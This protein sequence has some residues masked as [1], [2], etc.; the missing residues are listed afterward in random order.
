M[1]IQALQE[2]LD[3]LTAQL[4][5]SEALVDGLVVP[6]DSDMAHGLTQ[7]LNTAKERH[8][9]LKQDVV[10]IL[11]ELEAGTHIVTQ[12]QVINQLF[13]LSQNEN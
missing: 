7:D 12:F 10:D 9:Q 2:D 5:Y 6:G 3:T 1:Y 8:Q 13:K 11:E 4:G